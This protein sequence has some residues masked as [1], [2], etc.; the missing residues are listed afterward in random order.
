MLLS[1]HLNKGSNILDREGLRGKQDQ[2]REAKEGF[3]PVFEQVTHLCRAGSG[4]GKT[5]GPTRVDL[6]RRPPGR[7][8]LRPAD[9]RFR[10]G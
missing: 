4:H 8:R 2:P 9:L 1:L 6:T 10:H 5:A 3:A 7:Q